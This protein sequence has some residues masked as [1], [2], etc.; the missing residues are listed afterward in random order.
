MAEKLPKYSKPTGSFRGP[1]ALDPLETLSGPQIPRRLSSPLTQNPGS[2]SGEQ[3]FIT[4]YLDETWVDTNHT[5]SHQWTSS[6]PSKN[7]KLP[8]GKGQRFVVLHAGCEKG[9]LPGCDLV[10]ES[11]STDERD[12][13]PEMNAN[14]FEKWIK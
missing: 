4:V 12:Y 2:A 3:G 6:N 14:I 1:P 11:I 10:F 8:L 5:A 7:R 9:F 13:H